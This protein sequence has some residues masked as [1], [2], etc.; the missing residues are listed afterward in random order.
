MAVSRTKPISGGCGADSFHTLETRAEFVRVSD[1]V[2]GVIRGHPAAPEPF[3]EITPP[4]TT[5]A[6]RTATDRW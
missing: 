6:V 3:D 2:P 5:G 4:N 1:H